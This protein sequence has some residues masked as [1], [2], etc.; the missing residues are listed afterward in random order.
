M[1]RSN[2]RRKAR[3][4]NYNSY[5]IA[6]SQLPRFNIDPVPYLSQFEDR[7]TYHPDSIY[8]PIRSFHGYTTV[9][10]DNPTRRVITSQR[11]SIQK[12]QSR[13]LRQYSEFRTVSPRGTF[14]FDQPTKVLAC[15]RR[16]IREE[17]L[18]AFRKT[19]RRG[20]HRPRYNELS[21]IRCK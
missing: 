11:R 19:G 6:N 4:D 9:L 3:R 17:V 16:R 15:V 10:T 5:P 8:R 7:R 20:Q 2:N 13:S 1:S 14:R 21:G 12:P 18:H